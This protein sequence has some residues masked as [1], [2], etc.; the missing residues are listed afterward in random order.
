METME[1]GRHEID[2]YLRL[3]YS[4][5]LHQT[6][7]EGKNYWIAEIPQ[8]PGCKSHGSSIDEAIQSVQEA[9]RDWISD[10]L[11]RGERVPV[12]VERDQ[13]SGKILV[14]MS[15]SLHRALSLMAESENLS[16]NQLMVTILA[17]EV[18]RSEALDRLGGAAN[19]LLVK[20]RDI[21]HQEK[22]NSARDMVLRDR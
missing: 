17:K 20:I 14:R 2:Y 11:Q 7:D 4:I 16:L 9:K 22:E 12:P 10:S 21:V 13:Y 6:E 3:P 15:R 8:L 5:L 1:P 19:E 18:G